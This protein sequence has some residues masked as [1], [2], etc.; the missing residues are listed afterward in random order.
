M[1]QRWRARR[2]PPV[3]GSGRG[4]G[5]T[6]AVKTSERGA[7]GWFVT[8]EGPEGS[9]KSTQSERLREAA[10][11]AGQDV[12]LVREPGGTAAGE[13]VRAILMDAGPVG[14]RLTQRTDAL[15]FSAARAQLID[16]VIGPALRR[17]AL[18]ISDRYADS[19]LAYQG[20]GG[21]LPLDELRSVLRFAT[22]GL[23]PDRTILI[24][25]P[26]ELGLARK[27]SA[28]TTRFEAHFDRAFHE[29]VR[30]AY[31][32]FA[33]AEPDRWVVVDGTAPADDIF[34]A[35][36][37][38]LAGIPGLGPRLAGRPEAPPPSDPGRAGARMEH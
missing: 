13:R 29:R 25:L 7:K 33:V 19:T 32:S 11:A 27:S 2:R 38:I 3:G 12:V 6:R 23:R 31:L 5:Y 17:G 28:E 10:M 4:P 16:E 24:D 36:W 26:V 9:G 34:V 37:S 1:S 18:V 30:A 21:E 8:L 14:I 22:G 15:L 20:G 35:L